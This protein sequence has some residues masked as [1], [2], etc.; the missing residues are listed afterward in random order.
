[1]ADYGIKISKAGTA[2]TDTP[3]STTKKN[4]VVVST[5]DVPWVFQQGYVTSSQNIYHNLGY[6]PFFDAYVLTDTNTKA[7]AKATLNT[8]G[9]DIQ[10]DASY[11]YL[12]KSFGTNK[13]FYVLYGNLIG[14]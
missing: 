7:R 13:L 12:I 1:M 6:V 9:W 4:F 3:T 11:I 10:Y 8:Y 2:V 14:Q 5:D